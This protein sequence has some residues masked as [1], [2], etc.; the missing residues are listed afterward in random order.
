MQRSVLERLVGGLHCRLCGAAESVVSVQQYDPPGRA[1]AAPLV[2]L[3]QKCFDKGKETSLEHIK[4][5]HCCVCN[6]AAVVGAEERKDW[7]FY[8]LC[9]KATCKAELCL[10]TLDT[11]LLRILRAGRVGPRR[12]ASQCH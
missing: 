5:A 9:E 12:T 1:E 3:C 4:A 10:L 7:I 11:L 2:T 6:A 8:P